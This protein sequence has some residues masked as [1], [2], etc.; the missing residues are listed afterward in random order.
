[1][2]V[3]REIK[4]I[5]ADLDGTLLNDE[6][7]LCPG[8]AETIKRAREAGIYVVPVTGRPFKGIPECVREL[9]EIEYIIASN[10]AAII[11]AKSGEYIYSFSM[12]NE[13]S[14][15]VF[16]LLKSS[17]CL[18]EPFSDGVCYTERKII[19]SYIGYFKGTPVEEYLRST[20]VI[21][22]SL[23]A[24]FKEQNKRADEFFVSC[25]SRAER[26]KITAL[27]KK[28]EGVQFWF[29]DDR[30]IEITKENCDKG[31]ALETLCRHLN[32]NTENTMA[33]GDGE[34]DLLFLEKAGVSV[35]MENAA[36]SVKQRADIIADTNN[37]N[38]V[39]KIIETLL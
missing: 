12:T 16:N 3:N 23:E 21:C 27:L 28:T 30:Y 38:G 8:A 5:G 33:F 6:K 7:Q 37:N 26:N 24:L 17:D 15:E 25:E 39:C 18:F 19:D 4:L 34:N 1:M 11:D 31:S 13:K 10:G 36:K 35:A 29:Y 32:I 22:N 14:L 20:R 2:T 9:P